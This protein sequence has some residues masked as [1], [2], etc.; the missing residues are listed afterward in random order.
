LRDEEA[1]EAAEPG[2]SRRC[3]SFYFRHGGRLNIFAAKLN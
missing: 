1:P 2:R 3:V